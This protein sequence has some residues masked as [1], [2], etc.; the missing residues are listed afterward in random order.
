MDDVRA[1]A[2]RLVVPTDGVRIREQCAF[3]RVADVPNPPLVIIEERGGIDGGD[4]GEQRA[5]CFT[6]RVTPVEPD[7]LDRHSVF[8]ERARLV[9]AYDGGGAH[10]LAA[11]E[12]TDQILVPRHLTNAVG[13]AD[14]HRD[15][16]PLRNRDDDDRDRN[17]QELKKRRAGRQRELHF[18]R[19]PSEPGDRQRR[20]RED[21]RT[22]A[23]VA[24]LVG[25]LR[26]PLLQ[27]CLLGFGAR[28]LDVDLA[29]LAV[30]ADF[31]HQHH[32][33]A[34]GDDGTTDQATIGGSLRDSDRLT[35]DRGLV[36]V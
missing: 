30:H 11:G 21:G 15:R 27:G 1:V 31:G 10:R 7:V 28:Q 29:H 4:L 32:A 17:D 2:D 20:E 36:D 25:K 34:F 12:V 19:A 5:L 23:E 22:E 9:G 35:G 13:K 33:V 24:D 14:C 26:Q 3:G 16:Q 8:G 6:E 18:N